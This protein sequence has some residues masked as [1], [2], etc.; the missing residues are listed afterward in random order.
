MEPI[1]LAVMPLNDAKSLQDDL[2]KEGVELIL[3]HNDQTCT[4]GCSV[5]VEVLGFE[6]D[7]EAISNK[8]QENYQKLIE[9]HDV[10][11]E[12]INSVFDPNSEQVTCPACSFSFA[13][14]GAECPD[15]GL[16]IG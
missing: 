13:P 15:C 7:M 10:N 14:T 4:R 11:W 1:R 5:T 2:R 3:N 8:Y 12:A 16:V 9:G 6:K